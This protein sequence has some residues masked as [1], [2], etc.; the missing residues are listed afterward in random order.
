MAPYNDAD[1]LDMNGVW[2]IFYQSTNDPK[3]EFTPGYTAVYQLRL[4]ATGGDPET[5]Q[6]FTGEIITKGKNP[7]QYSG[8]TIYHQRGRQVLQMTAYFEPEQW[9]QVHAAQHRE[10]PTGKVP[11]EIIGVAIDCGGA[12]GQPESIAPRSFKLVKVRGK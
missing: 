3:F 6:T 11:H 2:D 9:V 10:N 8:R 5:G 7:I 4:K 1:P 12:L